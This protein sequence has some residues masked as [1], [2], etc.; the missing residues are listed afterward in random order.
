[1]RSPILKVHIDDD[2]DPE[3]V[4]PVTEGPSACGS[5]VDDDTEDVALPREKIEQVKGNVRA[6]VT[7]SPY[8]TEMSSLVRG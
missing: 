1:M 5:D 2:Q 7:L 8:L 6:S 3:N 4:G